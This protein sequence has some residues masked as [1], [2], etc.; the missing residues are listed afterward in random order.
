VPSP[1]AR[2]TSGWAGVNNVWKKKKLEAR[3]MLENAQTP[4]HPLYARHK[5]WVN[6]LLPINL[7]PPERT[8]RILN[9]VRALILFFIFELSRCVVYD[10][11]G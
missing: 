2:V 8:S 6:Y 3:I 1:I 4:H 9:K 7:H 5:W 10:F 11:A